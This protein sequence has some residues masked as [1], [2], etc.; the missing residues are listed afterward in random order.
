MVK[1]FLLGG[2]NL[3]SEN[4]HKSLHTLKDSRASLQLLGIYTPA[5]KRESLVVDHTLPRDP[6]RYI[7]SGSRDPQNHQERSSGS[8]GREA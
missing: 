2:L 5:I 7:S 4:T 3:F 8:K 6:T 1:N